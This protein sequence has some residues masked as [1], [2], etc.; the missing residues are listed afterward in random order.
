M[1]TTATEIGQAL[2][3]RGFKENAPGRWIKRIQGMH[4]TVNGQPRSVEA[5]VGSRRIDVGVVNPDLPLD[6]PDRGRS[7]W[8]GGPLSEFTIA[9]ILITA[10]KLVTGELH[11][12]RST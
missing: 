9:E 12:E 8:L 2:T 5:I 10:R 11:G 6:H 4:G 1:A 7:H 3:D